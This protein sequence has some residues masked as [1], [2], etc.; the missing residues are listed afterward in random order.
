MI[1]RITLLRM[2][3][4]ARRA[5]RGGGGDVDGA[6]GGLLD[7]RVRGGDGARDLVHEVRAGRLAGA[8]DGVLEGQGVGAAVADEADAVHADQRGAADLAPVEPLLHPLEGGTREEPADLGDGG[9]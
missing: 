9:A 6:G 4:V 7:Q 3:G 5:A 2:S 1:E 8:A